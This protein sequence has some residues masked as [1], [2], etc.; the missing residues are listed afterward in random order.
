MMQRAKKT[1]SIEKACD[2]LMSALAKVEEESPLYLCVWGDG[3][4]E[5]GQSVIEAHGADFFSAERGYSE[6]DRE[7]INDLALGESITIRGLADVQSITR[8]R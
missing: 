3:Y 2:E 5:P 1:A 6:E 8:I 4:G 7:A